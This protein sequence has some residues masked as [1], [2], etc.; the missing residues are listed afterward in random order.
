MNLG[1]RFILITS[2]VFCLSACTSKIQKQSPSK[3][4]TVEEN[5]V[6]VV[7]TETLIA[8]VP[9]DW[10]LT[11][12]LNNGDTRLSDFIPPNESKDDWSTKLSFESHAQLVDIDPIAIMMGEIDKKNEICKNIDHSNLFSGL[13]NNYP[14][15]VR[16]I[17][18]GEN[19]HTNLGEISL[20]KGIQGEDYFYIIRIERK[21]PS[22]EKG[23]PEFANKEIAEWS[24][25]LKKIT[26]CD[27]NEARGHACP[28]SIGVN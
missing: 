24:S 25:Y 7:S 13:E 14:T 11:F 9:T 16:L 26:L 8:Q 21:L 18:C 15:S 23:K 22:F 2:V 4:S 20:T 17:V 12:E 10:Q 28:S 5:V 1:L 19:A 3:S 27:L 6:D